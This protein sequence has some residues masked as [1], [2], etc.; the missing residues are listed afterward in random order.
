MALIKEE[1]FDKLELMRVEERQQYQNKMLVQ[2][3]NHAYKNAP[4]AK[5]LLDR[6]GVKPLQ[7]KTPK[8]LEKLPV[9]RKTEL[10]EM[11]K[12]EPPYGGLLTIPPQDVERVFLS[13][14]PV[15]EPIQHSGIKW[16]AKSFWAA[17]FR[18]GDIVANTFTYHMS[19]AG[20]LL[21]EAIR[22]C[23]ATAIPMGTGHT[24]ILIKTMFD[25]GVSGFVGTPSFLMTVIKQAEET[26]YDFRKDFRIRKAWFTG[27]MLSPSVRQALENIYGIDTH[28]AYAVTEPGG[29]IAY[30]CHLK[31]GMH[32]MDEYLIEIIDPVSG[33]QLGSGEV[34]EIVVTPVH[35]KTWGLLR[36]GTGDL[37]AY[38]AGV[39]A[40]GRTADRLTGIV[41][42]ASDAVKVRGMFVV[43]KQV[44]KVFTEF[45]EVSRFQILVDRP[46]QR[47]E[48]L[49]R[50]ELKDESIDRNTL[51]KDINGRFQS[52]CVVKADSIE[53]VVAGSIPTDCKVITD[54]RTWK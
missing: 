41:G 15:Y 22:D 54:R 33:E 45:N 12:A 1:Y 16:F 46:A 31:E 8:D 18:K 25:L 35:N 11:Q 14:G 20:I 29:A 44:E 42:R 3:I 9:T 10:V 13:P 26:G 21:H 24:E 7:I 23:G 2:T 19:P 52:V 37:S 49:I 32:F 51:A 47:D 38:K 36:F 27:E 34:G 39:C 6:A 5:E 4:A 40:C 43:A 17:G 30:E 53:F 28:Q 48:M 50:I